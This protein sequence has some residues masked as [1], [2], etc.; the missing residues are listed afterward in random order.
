LKEDLLGWVSATGELGVR[1][2]VNNTEEPPSLST[3][4]SKVKKK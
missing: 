3:E 2:G 1:G 4:K